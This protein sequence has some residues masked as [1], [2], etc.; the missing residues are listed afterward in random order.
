MKNRTCKLWLIGLTIGWL[1]LE[2]GLAAEPALADTNATTVDADLLEAMDLWIR[3][4]A[5]GQGVV[6][7]TAALLDACLPPPSPNKMPRPDPPAADVG[8]QMAMPGWELWNQSEN[9]VCVASYY[10]LSA[11]GLVPDSAVVDCPGLAPGTNDQGSNAG[12]C[13]AFGGQVLQMDAQ[14]HHVIIHIYTGENNTDDPGWGTWRCYG[15]DDDGLACDPKAT[16]VCPGNG[17]CG[18]NVVAGLGCAGGFGP[19]DVQ[20]SPAVFPAFG[21]AQESTNINLY[22]DGVY[23]TLPLKGI[24]IWNSHGFNLTGQ[25]MQVEGWNTLL[26][27]HVQ[28]YRLRGMFGAKNIFTQ[29]VPPFES[30]EYCSTET[31]PVGTS[32]FS[33]PSHTQKIHSATAQQRHTL[34]TVLSTVT[35]WVH[36]LGG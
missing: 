15:G 1:F 25:D 11:P 22:P 34:H 26:Y 28:Q 3:G 16:G 19:E 24:V 23:A 9:E 6:D 30:R 21:G 10:D 20:N 29:Q 4:G 8:M 7:G 5:P 33:L 18:S 36:A 31:L 35:L 13:F 2:R 14:S 17:V 32:M 27:N 12:K